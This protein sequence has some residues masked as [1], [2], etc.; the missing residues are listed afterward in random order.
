MKIW[1][2]QITSQIALNALYFILTLKIYDITHSNTAVSILIL[3]FTVP[4]IFFGYLAGV[5]VD[6][7]S[8]KKV[9]VSTNIVRSI[10]IFLMIFFINSVPLL[11]LLVFIL[12]FA[13]L[14]FIPAE[15]SAL[16]ALVSDLDLLGANSLFALSLQSALVVGFLLGGASLGLIGERPTLI[17]ILAL[18]VVSLVLNILL[19]SQIKA[20][21][22]VRSKG[23]LTNFIRG[24]IFVVTNKI[25]RDSVFFLT[26][27]TT[28]IF[29]L[30]TIG[31]GYVDKVLGLNIKYSSALVVAPATLGLAVGAIVLGNIGHK[32]NQRLIVNLGLTGLGFTFL[33][34]AFLG[35]ERF[36][37]GVHILALVLIFFLGVENAMVTIPVTT[38]F[39][40]NTPEEFRG[41]AYGLLSTFISGVAAL[42]V[43]LSG[44]IADLFSVRSVLTS[45]GI[46]VLSFGIYRFWHKKV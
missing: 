38:D 10:A 32:Y 23:L 31:P 30:A 25:V 28:I 16:P 6:Q 18:F 20:E 36:G 12:A 8:L 1:L 19:P 26:L 21:Q 42:P 33:I 34:L 40:K 46:V 9:M 35:Q 13:T 2:A 4:N 29:I 24:I 39:Q 45:L 37:F 22:E 14:F 15:G 3:A 17:A 27:A 11:F 7:L 41:R 43:L 44:A 5:Y